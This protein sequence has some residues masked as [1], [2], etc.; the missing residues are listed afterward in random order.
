MNAAT[1]KSSADWTKL[2]TL[3]VSLAALLWGA[4]AWTGAVAARLDATSTEVVRLQHHNKELS[5][6]LSRAV[7]DMSTRLAGIEARLE[8]LLARSRPAAP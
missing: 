4:A 2:G 3:V 6:A 1:L 7:T 5:D 8:L